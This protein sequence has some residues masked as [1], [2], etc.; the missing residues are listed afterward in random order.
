M[1]FPASTAFDVFIILSWL[2]VVA[3]AVYARNLASASNNYARVTDV[4]GM[5]LNRTVYVYDSSC[6]ERIA[7][8]LCRA[9]TWV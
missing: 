1:N 3:A 5:R 9:T 7:F 4:F 8:T 2:V 6:A